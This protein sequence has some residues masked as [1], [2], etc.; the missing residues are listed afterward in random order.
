MSVLLD[1]DRVTSVRVVDDYGGHMGPDLYDHTCFHWFKLKISTLISHGL[2]VNDRT[3]ALTEHFLEKSFKKLQKQ[4]KMDFI[5]FFWMSV[6]SCCP[7]RFC[8]VLC[9]CLCT[10]HFVMVTLYLTCLH[11]LQ[12]SFF[13]HLFNWLVTSLA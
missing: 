13:E 7:T 12:H 9:V 4:K 2:K 6:A 1:Q 5:Y 11:C 10:G 3:K 8:V